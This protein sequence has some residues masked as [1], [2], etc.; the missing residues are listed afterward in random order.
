M[1]I[2][3]VSL[4]CASTQ[5]F[6]VLQTTFSTAYEG[7]SYQNLRIIH[8]F[9]SEFLSPLGH[10]TSL[11]G[12]SCKKIKLH[13]ALQVCIIPTVTTQTSARWRVCRPLF[14]K[15]VPETPVLAGEEDE[16]MWAS[17]WRV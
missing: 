5:S 17:M 6:R 13:L 11:Q 9:A 7:A 4:S 8:H 2:K 14:S 10:V 1:Y 16:H 3:S 12:N 15:S